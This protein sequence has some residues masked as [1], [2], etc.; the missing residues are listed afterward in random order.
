MCSLQ[1]KAKKNAS[2]GKTNLETLMGMDITD[3][4]EEYGYKQEEIKKV[5]KKDVI[6]F[7]KVFLSYSTL[8]S[9]RFQIKNI[10]KI[11]NDYFEIKETLFWEVDSGDNIVEYMEETLK[12]CNAFVRKIH[13]ILRQ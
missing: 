6:C 13:S 12:K 2:K 7:F 9:D 5:K 11:L 8:D 10:A 4:F 3:L 1:T